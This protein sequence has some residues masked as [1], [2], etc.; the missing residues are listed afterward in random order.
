MYNTHQVA[1]GN[2]G[3]NWP[4]GISGEGIDGIN[5]GFDIRRQTLHRIFLDGLNPD[6]TQA[7]YSRGANF[8]DAI[9][10]VDGLL[11]ADT[12]L[13]LHLR[14]TRTGKRHG[15]TD[16]V[17]FS[18]GEELFVQCR[19]REY[20]ANNKHQHQQVRR[21]GIL[22]HPCQGTAHDYCSPMATDDVAT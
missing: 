18:G 6:R 16:L 11:D 19:R 3:D 12:Y 13:L 9:E 8:L 4:L 2:L 20:A 22:D 17:D 5:P 7:L 14:G 15:D 10:V 1:I 21:D